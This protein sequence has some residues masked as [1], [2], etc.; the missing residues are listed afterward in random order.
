MCGCVSCVIPCNDSD[1][2][3]TRPPNGDPHRLWQ[4]RMHVHQCIS[5]QGMLTCEHAEDER[6]PVD[7]V[8]DL[9]PHL[10]AQTCPQLL[11]LSE[12]A[13]QGILTHMQQC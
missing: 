1:V 8:K 12:A 5:W 10:Q 4:G 3:P 13:W 7:L 2:M 6:A 9:V 11:L